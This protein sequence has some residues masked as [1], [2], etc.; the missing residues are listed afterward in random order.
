M[1]LNTAA[2]KAGAPPQLD[3]VP[4]EKGWDN[5]QQR[6]N[7]CKA[8]SMMKYGGSGELQDDLQF[9]VFWSST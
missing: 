3:N 9:F 1:S 8:P 5:G 7:R 2:A 4:C 6:D